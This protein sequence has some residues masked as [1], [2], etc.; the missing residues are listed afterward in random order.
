MSGLA[1]K[2]VVMIVGILM[3][4]WITVVLWLTMSTQVTQTREQTPKATGTGSSVLVRMSDQLRF[5]PT[6]ITIKVGDTVEWR[7][8]GLI[9]HTVT[10]DPKRAPSSRNIELP[11]GAEAFDSGWVTSGKSFRYTFREPGV[12]RYV[13]LPHERARM[14]GT[15]IVG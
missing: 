3:I 10:A 2:T 13:C 5:V 8:I 9:P 6:E 11:D 12:Y 4:V 15:V 1:R 7:N 14:L